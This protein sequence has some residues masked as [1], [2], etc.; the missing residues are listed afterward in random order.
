MTALDITK[1]AIGK[2]RIGY[3]AIGVLTPYTVLGTIEDT[4]IH[5]NEGGEIFDPSVEL[6]VGG[7]V[8][9]FQ[10]QPTP[11]GISAEFSVAEMSAANLALLLPGA[12]TATPSTPASVGGGLSTTSTAATAVG[13]TSI[14]LTAVTGLAVGDVIRIDTS[15]NIEFRT[16]TAIN[17]LVASFFAPLSLAHASGVAVVEY[18]SDGRAVTTAPSPGRI[19]TSSYKEF[20][21]DWPRP[22]TGPGTV[23]IYRGL[24]AADTTYDLAV[25]P[26]TM[27]RVR[28]R[29]VGYRNDQNVEASPFALIQ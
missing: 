11:G 5:I 25:G 16:V 9:G 26:R 4:V 3:R 14:A 29:I 6:D 8:I 17:S 13:D 12:T 2:A 28:A 19:S 10:Y 22:D 27:G 20:R 7:P 23:V 1:Y 15:T 21:I 18:D 24:A